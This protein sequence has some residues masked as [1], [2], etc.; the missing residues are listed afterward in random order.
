M[1][2]DLNCEEC[3]HYWSSDC[4]V[5]NPPQKKID[6]KLLK[7]LIENV[8]PFWERSGNKPIWI[9]LGEKKDDL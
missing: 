3:G 5:C 7:D 8:K 4:D 1:I 2:E 6:P 9:E